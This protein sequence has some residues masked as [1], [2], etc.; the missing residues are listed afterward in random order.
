MMWDAAQYSAI[1][2]AGVAGLIYLGRV[3]H[4]TVRTLDAVHGLVEHQL[5]PN[6]GE[7]VYD[8]AKETRD[9]SREHQEQADDD[10]RVLAEVVRRLDHVERH[11][12]LGG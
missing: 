4:R 7:S 1:A 6:G 12:G 3:L 10:R 9:W 2:A 5:R 8:M 11:L